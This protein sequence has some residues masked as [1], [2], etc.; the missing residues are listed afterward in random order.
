MRGC[1]PET[2]GSDEVVMA[3]DTVDGCSPGYWAHGL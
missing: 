2:D 1:S 3:K